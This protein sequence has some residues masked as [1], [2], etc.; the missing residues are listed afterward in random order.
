MLIYLDIDEYLCVMPI[1]LLNKLLLTF[2]SFFSLQLAWNTM[3]K[4]IIAQSGADD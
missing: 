2:M 1:D 4:Y 3:I